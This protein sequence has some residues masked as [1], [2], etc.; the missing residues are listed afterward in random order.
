MKAAAERH[1]Q[2]R[3]RSMLPLLMAPGQSGRTRQPLPL[4]GQRDEGEED[5]VP[6]CHVQQRLEARRALSVDRVDRNA[7]W[8][9]AAGE[10][11]SR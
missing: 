8:K 10:T 7:L 11:A 3:P 6:T 9:A 4:Q 1:P 5:E 2:A